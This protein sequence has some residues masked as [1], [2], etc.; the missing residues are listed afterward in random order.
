MGPKPKPGTLARK[1]FLDELDHKPLGVSLKR[2]AD[3]EGG[4]Q[5]KI[6]RRYSNLKLAEWFAAPECEQ[7]L[8]L[9]RVKSQAAGVTS[10]QPTL[11]EFLASQSQTGSSLDALHTCGTLPMSPEARAPE[12]EAETLPA[13]DSELRAA[14]CISAANKKQSKFGMHACV[15]LW[16]HDRQPDNDDS[17]REHIEQPANP[18][19]DLPSCLRKI[20]RCMETGDIP[21]ALFSLERVA[22]EIGYVGDEFMLVFLDWLVSR[23]KQFQDPTQ[24]CFSPKH[25]MQGEEEG[26]VA[27]QQFDPS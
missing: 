6:L 7:Q 27:T 3:A 2:K 10:S 5:S 19:T 26:R 13:S 4:S 18:S 11:Q 22:R 1:L 9:D 21:G 23:T 15:E 12:S 24:A 17:L 14:G 20:Q 16:P 8:F 25:T